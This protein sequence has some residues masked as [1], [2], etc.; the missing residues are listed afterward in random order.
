M[1][2][3]ILLVEPDF[4]TKFP[5]LGLMKISTYHKRLGDNV[6]FVKGI[7][8]SV[9]YE[10]WDRVY[11]S[12]LFTYH[13]HVT[14]KTIKFYKAL[15]KNDPARIII[16]G[17]LASLLP[18]EI[19]RATGIK[20]LTGVL[21]DPGVLDA[22]DLVVENIIPDYELFNDIYHKYSLINDSF[23]GYSTR[24]CR[25]RC[26]FCGVHIL[27]PKFIDYKGIKPHVQKI[28]ELYGDKP[29]LV[30][31]DNNILV[32]KR[33]ENIIDDLVDLGFGKGEKFQYKKNGRTISKQRSVDFN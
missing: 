23:F 13:W 5:P 30:L 15:V 11:V 29:N 10:F 2:R 6:T 32:S 1:A 25:N 3:N 9:E 18:D 28:K 14:V 33:F 17:I 22:N 4:K 12:T 24:G 21:S 26:K 16:G 31:F 19:W 27:E 7:R 8:N 20:P